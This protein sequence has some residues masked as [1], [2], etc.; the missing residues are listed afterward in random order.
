MIEVHNKFQLEPE[1]LYLA[2]NILDRFLSVQDVAKAKL[3]LVGCV[4]LLL[5]SK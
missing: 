3:Q 4:A 5:A 2:V 1:T